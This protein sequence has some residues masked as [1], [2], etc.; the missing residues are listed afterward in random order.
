MTFNWAGQ[1]GQPAW[2][3]GSNDGSNIYVW[4]PSNFSVNYASSAGY[5]TSAG[6]ATSADTID[7]VAFRNT[8]S[9]ASVDA[10]AIASNGITYY[11]NGVPNFSGNASDGALYSQVYD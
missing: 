7:G 6:S 8:G 11:T 1:S 4:N 9:N 10:D 3:W 2:L 5:A